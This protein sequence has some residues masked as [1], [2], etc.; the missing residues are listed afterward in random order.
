MYIG[1]GLIRKKYE[2][3]L[4]PPPMQ[5]FAI[6]EF[7]KAYIFRLSPRVF[8]KE[9]VLLMISFRLN[10]ICMINKCIKNNGIIGNIQ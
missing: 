1:R 10:C 9:S 8:S 2:H 3:I 6:E 7:F 4:N 5:I